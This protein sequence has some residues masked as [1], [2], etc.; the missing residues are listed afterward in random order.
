[1]KWRRGVFVN[2]GGSIIID[3]NEREITIEYEKL[4]YICYALHVVPSLLHDQY[5]VQ[6]R[7]LGTKF[8]YVMRKGTV[9]N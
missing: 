6:Y 9:I 5:V 8:D 1:M 3:L 4:D 7:K 2:T